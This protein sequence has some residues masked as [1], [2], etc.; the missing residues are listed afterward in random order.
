M[1]GIRAVTVVAIASSTVIDAAFAG[2]WGTSPSPPMHPAKSSTTAKRMIL[3]TEYME[4]RIIKGPYLKSFMRSS[5]ILL[6]F[7]MI[8]SGCLSEEPVGTTSTSSLY[9]LTTTSSTLLA[10]MTTTSS[11]IAALPAEE[12]ARCKDMD[13][14]VRWWSI[15]CYDDIAIAESNPIK[16]RSARCLAYLGANST[17]CK[18]DDQRV[19]DA[20]KMGDYK[21]CNEGG[22]PRD[23]ILSYSE[24]VGDIRLCQ[25]HEV[26]EGYC[27]SQWAYLR[28]DTSHCE[29]L[30]DAVL[31]GNCMAESYHALA[32][33]RV[34]ESFCDSIDESLAS[35][36]LLCR[37]AVS[38][39]SRDGA[40]DIMPITPLFQKKKKMAKERSQDGRPCLGHTDC[41]SG[42][43]ESS[44]CSSESEG[45][46]TDPRNGRSYKIR[47]YGTSWW[48]TENLDVGVMLKRWE[49]PKNNGK[50]E[51]HCPDDDAA[52][53]DAYGGLYSWN[54][55]MQYGTAGRPG[56]CPK[57][58]H[59]PSDMEWKGIEAQMGMN[60]SELDLEGFRGTAD[61]VGGRLKASDPARWSFPNVG[62]EGSDGFGAYAGGVKRDILYMDLGKRAVWTTATK[63]GSR[64]D[65]VIER[66]VHHLQRGINR[67]W[68]PKSESRSLRCIK[69]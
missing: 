13:D 48:M 15:R 60:I 51:K 68:G 57:G 59:V 44:T 65:A 63:H 34:D 7:S 45:I 5:A 39:R 6:L 19:C 53:C 54:E 22:R 31:R 18:K 29:R 46:L 35:R 14:E 12:Y 20:L 25:R 66:S 42:Y 28:G 58:W 8:A 47:R 49:K 36:R 64:V 33:E 27:A 10:F 62:A 1:A 16:C 17:R 37:D 69:D 3:T 43:C 50:P 21:L 41:E 2:V 67:A 4:G 38:A 40:P 55:A 26:T 11:T 56:I 52:Q 30:G 61:N 32:V 23:C 24:L 9:T